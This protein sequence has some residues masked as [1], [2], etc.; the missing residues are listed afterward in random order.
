MYSISSKITRQQPVMVMVN[1]YEFNLGYTLFQYSHNTYF[2][3]FVFKEESAEV[4]E[5]KSMDGL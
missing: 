4:L 3:K 2:F 1:K 5:G